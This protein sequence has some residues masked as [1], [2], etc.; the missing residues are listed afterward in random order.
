MTE[1]EKNIAWKKKEITNI[2]KLQ[3]RLIIK[4]AKIATLPYK[5]AKTLMRRMGKVLSISMQVSSLEI[6]KQIIASQPLRKFPSGGSAI[7]CESGPEL[8]LTANGTIT[9]AN[10]NPYP[11]QQPPGSI[12]PVPGIDKESD[13]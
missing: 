12:R 4:A 5:R 1:R 13:V 3:S 11:H 9:T 2:A 10:N 6:Q 7:V 8:I